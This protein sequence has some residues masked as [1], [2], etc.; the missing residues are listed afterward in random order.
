MNDKSEEFARRTILGA[1]KGATSNA[2]ILILLDQPTWLWLFVPTVAGFEWQQ[3]IALIQS[4]FLWFLENFVWWIYSKT[5]FGYSKVTLL[6]EN[7]LF[8]NLK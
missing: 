2:K 4:K 8:T 6:L 3:E 5:N 1:S 7:N